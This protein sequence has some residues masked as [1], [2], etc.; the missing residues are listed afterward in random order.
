MTTSP[1]PTTPTDPAAGAAAGTEGR[2]SSAPRTAAGD[3]G[4]SSPSKPSQKSATPT[5][6]KKKPTDDPLRGSRTSGAWVALGAFSIVLV[7]LIIFIAQNTQ[8]ASVRFLAWEGTA[9]VSVL[10]LVA[11]TA[12]LMLAGVAATARILQL[13]RR[14]KRERKA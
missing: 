3:A 12:G 8:S 9:P 4:A 1:D 10:L 2:G 11:A 13:R 5:P 6:S 14:V 7:L